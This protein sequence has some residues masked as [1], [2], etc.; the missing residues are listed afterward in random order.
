MTSAF[1]E[2]KFQREKHM[3][4]SEIGRFDDRA[5]TKNFGQEQ[6]PSDV[7]WGDPLKGIAKKE[8]PQKYQ[9]QAP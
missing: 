7:I 6:D 5:R 8:E 3:T 2:T 4:N 9:F 1:Q